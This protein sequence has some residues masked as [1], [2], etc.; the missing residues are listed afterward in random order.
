MPSLIRFVIFTGFIVGMGY[1]GLYVLAT[2]FEPEPKEITKS[3]RNVKL[4][5][6]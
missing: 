2:Y 6:N 3:L 1:G 5:A 4:R